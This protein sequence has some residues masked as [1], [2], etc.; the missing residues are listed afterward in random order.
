MRK[1]I[2]IN[3]KEAYE[4]LMGQLK[5][6]T[7]RD[8]IYD[9]IS[10]SAENIRKRYRSIGDLEGSIKNSKSGKKT[11][12]VACWLHWANTSIDEIADEI[13]S[14]IEQKMIDRVLEYTKKK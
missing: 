11:K 7:I 2:G 8:V 14:N 9:E 10:M 6:L 13:I 1:K 4:M 5:H 12:N 3:E